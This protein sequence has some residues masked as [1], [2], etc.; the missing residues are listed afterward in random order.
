MSNVPYILGHSDADLRLQAAIL[1]PI[2]RRLLLEARLQPGMRVLDIGC[3]SGDIR[4]GVLCLKAIQERLEPAPKLFFPIRRL[5][6][7]ESLGIPTRSSAAKKCQSSAR[8]QKQILP[9]LCGLSCSSGFARRLWVRGVRLSHFLFHLQ[10][11]EPFD[12]AWQ[13]DRR[14]HALCFLSGRKRCPLLR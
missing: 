4:R 2:T 3:G 11:G 7:H 10:A 13:I 9:R 14:L 6:P 8:R 5:S 12:V 1:K